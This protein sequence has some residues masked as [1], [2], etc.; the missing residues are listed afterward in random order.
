MRQ[1]KPLALLAAVLVVLGGSG[2]G[3]SGKKAGGAAH[4]PAHRVATG[5]FGAAPQERSA[6]SGPAYHAIGTIIADDGFRPEHDGFSFPNYGGEAGA[7]DLTPGA[8]ADLFGPNVCASGVGSSCLLTPVAQA[9]LEQLNSDMKGGHCYGFSVLALRFFKSIVDPNLFGAPTVPTL[10]IQYNDALQTAIAEAFITQLLDPVRS[11][12]VIAP[13]NQLLDTIV[14]AL[15]AR[16]EV[17]TMGISNPAEQV[18]HAI[19]PYAVEDR[20]GGRF[21]VLI[22]D[23][24]YPLITRAVMFD[25]TSNSW[26]YEAASNPND[27]TSHFTGDANALNMALDPLTPGLGPQACFFCGATNPTGASAAK[28]SAQPATGYQ[29]VALQGDPS[30]HSH[31]LITDSKGRKT[32]FVNGRL[33]TGIPGS[34]ALVPYADQ[35]WR[36]R[37]EPIYRIPAGVKVS[38]RV[39]G[40]PLARPVV[41]NVSLVAPGASAVVKGLRVG[42]GRTANVDFGAGATSVQYHAGNLTGAAPIVQLARA[43]SGADFGVSF[44]A[45]VLWNGARISV[46][47]DA[48]NK[49]VLITTP[50]AAPASGYGLRLNRF[51]ALGRQDFIHGGLRLAPGSR[52]Q[53]KFQSFKRS[54]ESLPL[55]T[56]T[57]NVS[58]TTRLSG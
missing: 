48:T 45:P 13:P 18:G 17:Y 6:G 31:L 19:T 34:K 40:A 53:L 7:I 37:P 9:E 33:V 22:Y 41:E 52:A 25:R 36:V 10:N 28:V 38:V 16:Q 20:G 8:L 32:G 11:A 26:S 27:P 47:L 54:G 4:V 29:Q 3:G 2:C 5:T 12:R 51:T 44:K 49:R 24:N 58:H 57:G 15:R 1:L 55:S 56:V 14:A 50:S 35:V 42:P 21:A 39:E 46:A 43:T 23:N 30:N